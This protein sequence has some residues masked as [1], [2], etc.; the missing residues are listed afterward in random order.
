MQEHVFKQLVDWRMGHPKWIIHNY[1][2]EPKNVPNTNVKNKPRKQVRR[3]FYPL[4]KLVPHYCRKE[5][6]KLYLEPL[7]TSKSQLYNAYKDD[8]CPREKAETLS[9]TRKNKGYCYIWKEC[10]GKL[11]SDELSTIIVTALWKFIN[12]NPI[13]DDRE[14]MLYSNSCTNQN[15][16]AVLSN[17][18]LNFSMQNKITITQK[19]LQKCCSQME[20]DSM[21]SVTEKALR[22]KNQCSGRL[23]IF[24]QRGLQEKSLRSRV[25]LSSL[26]QR[27]S[28]SIAFLQVPEKG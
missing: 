16:K 11:T 9:I 12:R 23:C 27:F 3:F 26:L 22:H 10:E 8:F 1:D 17:T 24:G 5:P 19:F 7:S 6:S 15:R 4:P 25:S 14:L 28:N 20:C 21:H 2:D 18:L 13:G